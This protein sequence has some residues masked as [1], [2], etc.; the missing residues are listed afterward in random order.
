M[1]QLPFLVSLSLVTHIPGVQ[2]PA[3]H[4][5]SGPVHAAA[6]P[7]LGSAAG[8]LVLPASALAA[9]GAL[10]AASPAVTLAASAAASGE[11]HLHLGQKIALFFQQTGLPD[12]AVLMLISALPA[13]ELR[14]GVAGAR[15]N[16]RWHCLR[17][18]VVTA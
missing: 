2:I 8:R 5:R 14:G 13:V 11:A 10:A 1:L 16:G 6:R 12:W 15:R 4:S 3:V 18:R 17:G 9:A 7:R